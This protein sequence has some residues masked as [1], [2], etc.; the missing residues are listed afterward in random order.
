MA[1]SIEISNQNVAAAVASHAQAQ[2]LVREQRAARFPALSLG[3]GASRNGRES[4]VA[5]TVQ[6][7]PLGAY[8]LW[9]ARVSASTPRA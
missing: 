9:P 2:A 1:E 5:N 4:G 7:I 3:A 6:A 8:S